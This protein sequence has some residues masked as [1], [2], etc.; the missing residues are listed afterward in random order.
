MWGMLQSLSTKVRQYWF[1]RIPVECSVCGCE[2]DIS[3]NNIKADKQ[4]FCSVQCALAHD[5]NSKK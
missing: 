2:Y 1:N 4:Y 5:A 3:I